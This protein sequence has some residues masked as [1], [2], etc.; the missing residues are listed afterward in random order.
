MCASFERQRSQVTR[1]GAEAFHWDRRL[2]VLEREVL[3]F[4]TATSVLFP[5]ARPALGGRGEQGGQGGP[6]WVRLVVDVVGL[7]G[8]PLPAGRAEPA[9]VLAGTAAARGRTSTT[10]SRSVGS[11]SSR[12]PSSRGSGSSS[13]AAPCCD[14]AAR[15][16]GRVDEQLGEVDLGG[17]GHRLQAP[18]ALT[19]HGRPSP[20]R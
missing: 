12:S 10:A 11:R 1:A 4:G 6:P 14:H 7:V 13:S 3:R 2:W 17:P 18:R 5:V 16:R 15:V 8:Q 19:R 9:A 20:S